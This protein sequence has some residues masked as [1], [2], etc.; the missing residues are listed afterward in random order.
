MYIRSQSDRLI[1]TCKI[2]DKLFVILT[3][4]EGIHVDNTDV[5]GRA[6]LNKIWK[7]VSCGSILGYTRSSGGH[8]ATIQWQSVEQR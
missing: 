4:N 8:V 2:E 6:R 5:S 1:L 7:S 3:M